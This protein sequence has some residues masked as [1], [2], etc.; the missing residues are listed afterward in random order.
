MI[1]VGILKIIELNLAI[2]L[3]LLKSAPPEEKAQIVVRWNN[4]MEFW[5]KR[6]DDKE[7]NG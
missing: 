2:I 1:T 3:E 4:F 6:L 7:P 5:Q